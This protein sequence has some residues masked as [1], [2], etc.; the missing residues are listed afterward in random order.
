MYCCIFKVKAVEQEFDAEDEGAE[1][2]AR[3]E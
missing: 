3:T 2:T 1:V